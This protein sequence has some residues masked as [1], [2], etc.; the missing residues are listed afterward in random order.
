MLYE[1][2]TVIKDFENNTA[3]I[4]VN[5]TSYEVEVHRDVKVSKTPTLIV[6]TSYSIHYTKLY[7]LKV[8]WKLHC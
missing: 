2:I 7:E 1:V 8:L 4:E 5:G 3:N 6:I